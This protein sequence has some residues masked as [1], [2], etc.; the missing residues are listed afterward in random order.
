[1]TQTGGV[2]EKPAKVDFGGFEDAAVAALAW[3]AKTVLLTGKGEPTLYPEQLTEYLERLYADPF[4]YR[5]AFRELQTNGIAL[6]GDSLD[7]YLERWRELRLRTIAVSVAHF[8]A[9]ANRTI[10]TPNKESYFDLRGLAAKLNDRGYKMRLSVIM[11]KDYIDDVEG[12]E[13]LVGFAKKNQ[14]YQLTV[15]PV[16]AAEDSRNPEVKEWT[17]EH[18]VPQKNLRAI[19]DYLEKEGHLVRVL[20]HGGLVYDIHGQNLCLSNALTLKPQTGQ[21]RQMIFYPD[22]SIRYDWRYMGASL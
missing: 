22:G 8:E 14:I 18:K 6:A 13:A 12:I 4:R 15:R 5:Y 17:L 9:E 21:I 16:E 3:G 19:H 2:E 10:F 1:M 7:N 20:P 11:L